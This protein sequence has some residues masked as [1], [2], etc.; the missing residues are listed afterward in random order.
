[1]AHSAWREAY[2]ANTLGARC[3]AYNF[4]MKQKTL[5][6]VLFA[7][8]RGANGFMKSTPGP[9]AGPGWNPGL[10]DNPKPN[11]NPKPVSTEDQNG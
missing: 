11:L 8:G 2:G 9:G 7:L 3:K 1:M 5:F 6:P 10:N 4:F